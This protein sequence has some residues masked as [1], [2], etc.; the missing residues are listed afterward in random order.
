MVLGKELPKHDENGRCFI[1]GD[2]KSKFKKSQSQHIM[3][4]NSHKVNGK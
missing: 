2:F 3:Q 4:L 1:S